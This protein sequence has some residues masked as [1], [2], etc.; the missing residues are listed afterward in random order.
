M[1]GWSE[2]GRALLLRC[3][4]CGSR[5]MVGRWGRF[6]EDCPGCGHHYERE[7]GYWLGA[8]LLNTVAAVAAL[9]LALIGLLVA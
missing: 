3:P 7:E 1:R 9:A 4:R 6:R 8:V 2:L 5:G